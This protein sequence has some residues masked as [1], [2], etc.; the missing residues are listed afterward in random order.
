LT[1]QK[2]ERE[3]DQEKNQEE[4]LGD[5]SAPPP[6]KM[7]KQNVSDGIAGGVQINQ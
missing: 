5:A 1:G 3:E 2:R 7:K 6:T 4:S